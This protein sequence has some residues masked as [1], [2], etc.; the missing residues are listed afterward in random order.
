MANEPGP[1]H[2]HRREVDNLDFVDQVEDVHIAVNDDH[3]TP[4]QGDTRTVKG[5]FY[6]FMQNLNV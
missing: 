3:T 1:S 5:M 6:M 2:S 4:G